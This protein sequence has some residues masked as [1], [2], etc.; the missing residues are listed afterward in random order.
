MRQATHPERETVAQHSRDN[1]SEDRLSKQAAL[2][3]SAKTGGQRPRQEHDA[4]PPRN[5]ETRSSGHHASRQHGA[6]DRKPET[7]AEFISRNSVYIISVAAVV[8]VVVLMLFF[9]RTC[10]PQTQ[11]APDETES[12]QEPSTSLA[13]GNLSW[14]GERCSYIVDGKVK[15]KTGID[16][17]E[18]QHEIDWES[19]AAD[20]I[21]FVMIRLGYRGA[22]EGDLYLD[23]Y[24]TSYLEG[25]KA[26]GLD[27]GIYFFSQAKTVEEA[28]EEADFVLENLGHAPLEYP[29]AFD[30][31]E[32]VLG[33]DNPRTSD[34]DIE[35]M[36]AIADAFCDR[37]EAAGYRSLIYGNYHDLSRFDFEKLE[38][39]NLWWAEYDTPTPNVGVDIAMWQYSHAGQVAGIDTPTDMNIDLTGALA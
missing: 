4:Q 18:N 5:Q 14:N 1:R 17:S 26:A 36:T 3:S 37:V 13:W 6:T 19:V 16:V 22:T 12:N 15:S 25:A 11:Q 30:S 27:C 10:A 2:L 29:I 7:L 35:T 9:L 8:I 31:E 28:Q 33:L 23:E 39:R 20:G 34:L 38:G 21:D 24:Y 32:A